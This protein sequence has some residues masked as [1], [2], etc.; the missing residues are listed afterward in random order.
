M[1]LPMGSGFGLLFLVV[2]GCT[3]SGDDSQ[4][5]SDDSSTADDT[6]KVVCDDSITYDSWAETFFSTYCTSCHSSE[7]TGTERHGAPD[8]ANF[9]TYAGV[10]LKWNYIIEMATGFN[11]RMPPSNPKPTDEEREILHAWLWCEFAPN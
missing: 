9:N 8:S 4:A 2:L 6:G 1:R 5:P 11:P 7:R 10:E 3:D